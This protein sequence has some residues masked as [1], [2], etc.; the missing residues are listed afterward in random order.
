MKNKIRFLFLLISVA[1]LY[2]G[3]D[4]SA[5]E[6]DANET[7]KSGDGGTN[8][9]SNMKKSARAPKKKPL[10]I[11]DTLVPTAVVVTVSG[12]AV[13]K[14][15]FVATEM[16]RGKV[17]ALTQG[18]PLDPLNKETTEKISKNRMGILGELIKDSLIRQ[19]AE[20]KGIKP[21]PE[22]FKIREHIY[23]K[24]MK[25]GKSTL[26]Q[27]AAEFGPVHGPALKKA[28]EMSALVDTVLQSSTTNDLFK[29]TE[30]EITNY[31][32]Y[33]SNYNA[34]VTLENEKN[35]KRARAA[36]NEILEMIRNASYATPTNMSALKA[37][38]MAEAQKELGTN[39]VTKAKLREI[40]LENTNTVFSIVTQKYA[41]TNVWDGVSWQTVEMAD[42]E[43]DNP[44][45]QWLLTAK[46]GDISDP[47]ETDEGIA[48]VGLKYKIENEPIEQG[49]PATYE[50]ELV[51]CLFYYYDLMPEYSTR[52]DIVSAIQENRWNAA[53]GSL[54]EQLV[55][56]AAIE[57][58]NGNNLF[59]PKKSGKKK[60]KARQDN[61]ERVKQPPKKKKKKNDS[62]KK[63]PRKSV[64]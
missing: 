52:E 21:S 50:Y 38:L 42:F 1:F 8:L 46:V 3:C 19:Y 57:F 55:K 49:K 14:E 35:M 64:S 39:K 22:R 7:R 18:F 47:I 63:T 4:R 29:V 61:N 44:L 2:W 24:S 9:V 40:Y 58:P 27:V 15:D 43:A 32:M 28:V 12:Q 60:I 36:K 13:T 41:D 53:M 51:R 16:M 11:I 45:A 37:D 5:V 34:S 33:V 25:R 30:S 62:A 54:R 23:L 31:V 6:N 48:I 20:K 59:Y 26:D 17:W 56:D 10:P